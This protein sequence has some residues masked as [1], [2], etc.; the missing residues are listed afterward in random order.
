MYNLIYINTH[1]TGRFIS[2]YGYQVNTPALLKLAKEGTLFTKAFSVSPTCSPSRASMLTST[3]PHVNGMLGLAQRGFS[4]NNPKQHLA[5]F[6]SENGYETV[7]CGIQHEVSWYFDVDKGSL[8]EIG[9]Q[10]VLTNSAEGYKKEEYHLWDRKNAETLSAWLR[11]RKSEQ[12]FMISYGLHSTHRPYPVEVADNIDER[13]IKPP[14]FESNAITRKDH[15]QFLTSAQYAD[16]SI[17]LILDTLEELGL[18]NNTIILFTTDHGVA[19]PFHKCTLRDAGI[20]V[21]MIFRH[22]TMGH[23]KVV[24]QLVSHLDV[25][26]TICEALGLAVP[27][28]VEG[29]SF[30]KMLEDEEYR[31]RDEIYAQVNFHTSYEPIRCVRTERYKYVRYFDTSWDKLNLSNIDEGEPKDYLLARGLRD[32]KKDMEAF[33]D[34][35]YDPTESNNLIAA[36]EYQDIIAQ[37]RAKLH[38]YMVK[39]NDPLLHGHFEI[40]PHYKVNVKDAIYPSSKDPRDYDPRGRSH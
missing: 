18:M 3:L 32:R 20:G 38:D 5:A 37:L 22:P 30:L 16:E 12:P 29:K 13:Y 21:S 35:L 25:F 17:K 36:A 4:L 7:L 15:A 40:K 28:Y 24:D 34:C 14:Y 26:P 23:G 8:H 27:D 31:I 10:Q 19:L 1:D 2:P 9:Y 33:Y 39:T 6:L 11:N